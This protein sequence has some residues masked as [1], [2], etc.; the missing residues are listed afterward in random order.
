MVELDHLGGALAQQDVDDLP[1]AELLPALPL[2]P[3]HRREHLLRGHRAVPGLGR[4]QA[5]VAVA[6]PLPVRVLAEVGQEL[7]AAAPGGLAQGEHGV[8]VG[9]GAA[10]ERLVALAELDQLALLHDVVESVRHPGRGGQAVAPRASGLLVVALDRLGQV[11]VGDEPHVRLV[12]AHAEGDGR[13]DHQALLAQEPRLVR[14]TGARVQAGVVGH[15]LDAVAREEL[16][17]LLDRV[18]REAVHDARVPGVLL[19]QEAQKLLL[20]VGL[21]HDP[22]L[23]VGAVEAGHE[24][25]R[26]RHVQPLGDLAVGGVGGRRRERQARH[27]RPALAEQRQGEVVGPEVVAPLGDAVRLVDGEEG[28]LAA[29]EQVEGAV[30]AQPLGRQ[31]QQVQLAREE[32]GLH[33]A[34][35]VEVLRGVHEPGAH[36][37]GPQRVH[38]VLHQCDQRGHHD[39]RAGPDQGRDLVAQRLS[40][41]GRHEHDGVTAGDHVLDDRL[42]LAAEGVVP[43]DPVQG[44]ERL[45]VPVPHLRRLCHVADHARPAHRLAPVLLP[46][47]SGPSCPDHCLNDRGPRRQRRSYPQAARPGPRQ[48]HDDRSH[49]R[50]RPARFRRTV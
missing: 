41:A 45:A 35:L 36:T 40:A 46:R 43:E 34:P 19:A 7:A 15:R 17:G 39:A 49:V 48:G 28:D 11:Q 26:R 9:L 30:Q 2:Q 13:D 5:G 14:R 32:L 8:Q 22:V 20:G 4:G 10:A 38:L 18:A 42:L 44:G 29:G 47:P 6:A 50:G 16:G 23:D 27:V 31:V 33:H 25:P 12:D 37:E 3:H 1:G 24:V 21:R